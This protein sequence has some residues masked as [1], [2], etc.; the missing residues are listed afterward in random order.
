MDTLQRTHSFSEKVSN[1]AE[2]MAQRMGGQFVPNQRWENVVTA[3]SSETKI[4]P[5]KSNR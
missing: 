2:K 3:S 4:E 5:K 1:G